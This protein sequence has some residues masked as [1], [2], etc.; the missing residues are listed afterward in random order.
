MKCSNFHII[1][2]FYF[3]WSNFGFG[4][5]ESIKSPRCMKVSLKYYSADYLVTSRTSSSFTRGSK[6]TLKEFEPTTFE[7]TSHFIFFFFN[8]YLFLF[9]LN[10]EQKQ[11]RSGWLAFLPA[12][13]HQHVPL[14]QRSPLWKWDLDKVQILHFLKS[15]CLD[16]QTCRSAGRLQNRNWTPAP[17]LLINEV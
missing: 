4:L 5:T 10:R 14:R 16:Q 8:L 2:F 6:I 13:P 1:W 3:K 7:A 15:P 11:N 12:L 9:V 17:F